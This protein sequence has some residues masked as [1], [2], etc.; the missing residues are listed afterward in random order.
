MKTFYR[1]LKSAIQS[2][3]LFALYPILALWAYNFEVMQP[4]EVVLPICISVLGTLVVLLILRLLSR[5]WLLAGLLTTLVALLFF[6]YGH[7][8]GMVSSLPK[9]GDLFGRHRVLGPLWFVLLAVGGFLILKYGRKAGDLPL[10]LNCI[11]LALLVLTGGQLI[12]AQYLDTNV[13]L[14]QNVA[15]LQDKNTF[16]PSRVADRQNLPDIY[17]IVLDSYP[18]HDA[19]LKGL[20]IDNTP[21]LNALTGLG[22]VIPTCNMSNYD[23]TILSMPSILNMHYMEDYFPNFD[24]NATAYDHAWQKN[25]IRHSLVRKNLSDLG[26]KTISFE[27]EYDWVEIPDADIYYTIQTPGAFI[28][29]LLNSTEFDSVLSDTSVLRLL[30]NAEEV[31]PWVKEQVEK[32]NDLTGK[33]L[34]MIGVRPPGVAQL[35]YQQIMTALDNLEKVPSIPGQKFVYLHVSAPHPNTVLGPNGEYLPQ[36]DNA[37][38][39]DTFTYLDKRIPEILGKLI[40]NSRVPPVI[41]LQGD[42]GMHLFTYSRLDNLM[43]YYLPGITKNPVYP[44]ITPVNTFRLVFNAYFDGRYPLLKDTS[45]QSSKLHPLG[46]HA[47][48][49]S[50]PK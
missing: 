38:Y 24:P 27:S 36:K 25:I 43:A 45:F 49:P 40:N 26:Y 33:F 39:Q 44:S 47:V 29:A 12:Y 50:C 9:I 19:L 3:L 13:K 17:F 11:G 28:Q 22:F 20:K 6:T 8:F 2:P 42:H 1:I 37:D 10:F 15:A 35:K 18:R 21:F 46:F 30:T 5:S 41:I 7:V 14:P 34:G 32:I 4:I 31:S 16:D 48:P 23:N